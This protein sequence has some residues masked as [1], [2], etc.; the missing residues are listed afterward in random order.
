MN[1]QEI[2]DR[3]PGISCA[4]L[5]AMGRVRTECF[6]DADREERIP[7]DENTIFPACS[8][9]KFVTA[10]C[11]MKL[12]DQKVVDIDESVNT[13]LRRWKLRT[14][15]GTESDATIRSLL[16]HT[17]GIADG[18]DGFY[19]LRRND[20]PVTLLDILDGRTTYNNRPARAEKPQ[21]T[22]FEYSDAGYCILQLLVEEVAGQ[23]FED[24]ARTLIF[25][26]LGVE[27]TFFASPRNVEAFAQTGSMA[28]GYDGDGLP[29]SGKSPIV[30]DLAASALWST[31]KELLAV[32]RAFLSAM[33]GRSTF[34]SENSAREMA[35]PVE[36]FPWTGLGLFMAGE[37]VLMS[38]GWGENGQCM[39]KMNTRTGAVSAVMTNRNPEVDQ[40]ASG[41]EWLVNRNMV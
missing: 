14:P 2:L 13:Y 29:L 6:G 35:A 12:H 25:D 18:E 38:Q 39:L 15:D 36:K 11:V 41:V 10:I 34:L 22:A 37:N 30:P 9:S 19:G 21:G 27:H 26:P 16:C 20:P 4:W 17:A 24:V 33:K 7:V 40:T 1:M 5:D 3:F 23:A 32:A 8:I 28:A 31:P